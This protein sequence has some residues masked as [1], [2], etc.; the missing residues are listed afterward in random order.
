MQGFAAAF[1]VMLLPKPSSAKVL[2]RRT[3]AR[4][5]GDLARLYGGIIS[6]ADEGLVHQHEYLTKFLNCNVSSKTLQLPV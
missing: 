1:V 6:H 4:N 2:V 5:I 3:L